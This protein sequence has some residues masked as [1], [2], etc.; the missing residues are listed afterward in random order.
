[1]RVRRIG[2]D[3]TRVELQMTPMI[4]VVFQLL[5]FFL[6]TFKIR[7]IEGEI[8]VTMPPPEAGQAQQSEEITVADRIHIKLQ[9]GAGGQLANILVEEQA[10]GTDLA[11]LGRVLRELAGNP[12]PEDLE[13]EIDADGRLLYGHVI[14][15]A[16][17][18]MRSGIAK[19]RFTDPGG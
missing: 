2:H 11:A 18:V 16:T 14:Q 5:I 1:M 15:V 10:V 12:P 17:V 19:V 6:F 7:P 13:A 9:A 4:D 3:E 8:A